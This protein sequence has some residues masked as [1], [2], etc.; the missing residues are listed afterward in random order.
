MILN[1][2]LFLFVTIDKSLF[3]FFVDIYFS[4]YTHT[5]PSKKQ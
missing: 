4:L 1:L 2:Y 3:R 5:F